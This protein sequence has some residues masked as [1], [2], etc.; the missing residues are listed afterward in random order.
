MGGL[1]FASEAFFRPPARRAAQTK[2]IYNAPMRAMAAAVLFLSLTGGGLALAQQTSDPDPSSSGANQ[3]GANQPLPRS[4]PP[5]PSANESSSRQTIIDLSPPPNDAKDH[6]DS[7]VDDEEAG[8]SDVQEFHPFDPHKA[9]KDVE[10]AEFY[11]KRGNYR[12]AAARYREALDYKP[13]DAEATIGL[14]ESLEKLGNKEEAAVN[15]ASYLKILPNGPR[16][17][18]ARRGLERLKPSQAA[19]NR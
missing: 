10:V 16:A 4:S 8:K 2:G 14:A 11:F 6:P 1:F 7:A 15:Y 18:D 5:P 9:A 13:N 17:E 12:A 19:G 3:P